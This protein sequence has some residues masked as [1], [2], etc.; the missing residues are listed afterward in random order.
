[1]CSEAL[2]AFLGFKALVC[3]QL[4]ALQSITG[5]HRS[6]VPSSSGPCT[7]TAG[8]FQLKWDLVQNPLFTDRKPKLREGADLPKFT[9]QVCSRA[10]TRS[11]V[12]WRPILPCS[13]TYP[14]HRHY[15]R[16]SANTNVLQSSSQAHALVTQTPRAPTREKW[17]SGGHP[18]ITQSKPLLPARPS[19]P[20]GSGWGKLLLTPHVPTIHAG[21]FARGW[22]RDVCSLQWQLYKDTP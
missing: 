1:M 21:S 6:H 7:P 17:G 20:Q 3:P 16:L 15:S 22:R 14:S 18:D 9:Q 2:N 13:P 10:V 11:P 4:S 19:A 12:P 8:S 5:E